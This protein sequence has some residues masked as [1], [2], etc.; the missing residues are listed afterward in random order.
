M[1][2]CSTAFTTLAKAQAK[3]LGHPDLPLVVIPH[4]FGLR[5]REEVCAMAQSCVDEIARLVTREG[6]P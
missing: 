4:P 6:K 2:V 5:R 3:A 1:T